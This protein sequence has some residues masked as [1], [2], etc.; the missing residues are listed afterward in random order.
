[1]ETQELQAQIVQLQQQGHS[2]SQIAERLGISRTKA[3][4]LYS[5]ASLSGFKD[6]VLAGL[7]GSDAEP[8]DEG[9][10][11]LDGDG[12]GD[13]LGEAVEPEI[14]TAEHRHGRYG[15][16]PR[17]GG[18]NRSLPARMERNRDSGDTHNLATV[19]QTL[20]RVLLNQGQMQLDMIKARELE[21]DAKTRYLQAEQ[22]SAQES[23]YEPPYATKQAGKAEKKQRKLLK[24][25]HTLVGIFVDSSQGFQWDIHHEVT[26]YLEDVTELQEEIEDFAVDSGHDPDGLFVL[27]VLDELY[28]LIQEELDKHRRKVFAGGKLLFDLDDETVE[29]YAD[30]TEVEDLFEPLEEEDEEDDDE[31]DY[32]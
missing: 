20:E 21:F 23:A 16:R 5:D 27:D 24:R 9:Q 1:M 17:H 15:Q 14:I 29:W 10:P 3:H 18:Q 30:A 8:D 28:D 19:L 2:F 26:G 22:E 32:R 25:F 6:E 13:D 31:D 7:E 11:P 4:R 12:S